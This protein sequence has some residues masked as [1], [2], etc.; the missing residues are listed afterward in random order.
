MAVAGDDLLRFGNIVVGTRPQV[1]I[2]TARFF[3]W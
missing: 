2:L 3:R 1:P